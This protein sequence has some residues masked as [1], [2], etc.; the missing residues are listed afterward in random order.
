M[1]AWLAEQLQ[2]PFELIHVFDDGAQPALP[3]D[4]LLMDPVIRGDVAARL[5][6]RTRALALADLKSLAQDLLTPDAACEVLDGR[7]VPTLLSAAADRRA[8]LLL[9]GTA[10]RAGLDHVL[11]GSVSG[12][13][14]AE[15]PCPVV[16]VPPAAAIA[17]VGPVVVGDDGSAHAR[18]ALLHATALAARLRRGLIRLEVDEGDP[19]EVIGATANDLRA[20]LIATGTRG[21]GSLRAELFGSVSTGLVQAAGRPVMLVPASAGEPPESGDGNARDRP[22]HDRYASSSGSRRRG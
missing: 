13:L 7:V 9:S 16:T 14:A 12:R 18:R 4:G 19:V 15:A 6:D 3:R 11:Q 22:V 21:R 20:C 1:A 10:A 8:V 2:A 5:N 17:D